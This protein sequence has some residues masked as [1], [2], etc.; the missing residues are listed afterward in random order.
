MNIR[1]KISFFQIA[2]LVLMFFL[3]IACANHKQEE[4]NKINITNTKQVEISPNKHISQTNQFFKGE[5]TETKAMKLLY[6]NFD[7]VK[8]FS[9][10]AP[11]ISAKEEMFRTKISKNNFVYT[12]PAFIHEFFID[13]IQAVIILTETS[14][15]DSKGFPDD[16]HAC[17][18]IL[19]AALFAKI[20]DLWCLQNF[21]NNLGEYGYW[22]QLPQASFVK[23]G[24]NN[25]GILF[26]INDGN[27]GINFGGIDLLGIVNDK[28][29]FIASFN[30]WFNNEGAWKEPV[31][32][33]YE[34]DFSFT[35]NANQNFYDIN[36]KTYGTKPY[37]N[38][39]DINNKNTV[40]FQEHKVYSY[41]DSCSCYK[42]TSNSIYE[43]FDFKKKKIVPI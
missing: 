30:T 23:F 22:G 27:Q 19:G 17:A 1:I 38:Y 33:S 15:R 34:S 20:N 24:N 10:W 21:E 3:F 25:Y 43:S 16:C 26:E 8:K 6:G 29:T 12:S 7:S 36:I 9:V 31:R 42:M 40:T 13:T 37:K 2:L 35:P 4:I 14:L 39:M 41:F 28:F 11:S 32:Y 5:F 18:P